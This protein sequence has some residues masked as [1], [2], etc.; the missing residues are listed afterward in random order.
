MVAETL[1]EKEVIEGKELDELLGFVTEEETEEQEERLLHGDVK[2][3]KK[4]ELRR[5]GSTKPEV[6]SDLA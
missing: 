1:L 5:K 6:A 2:E 4:E 3:S